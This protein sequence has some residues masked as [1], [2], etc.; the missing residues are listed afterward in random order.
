[1]AYEDSSEPVRRLR[2]GDVIGNAFLAMFGNF[3]PFFFIMLLFGS[4]P[5]I[6]LMAIGAAGTF[7]VDPTLLMMAGPK[8]F[9]IV[10]FTVIVYLLCYCIQQAAIIFGCL[11]YLDGRKA[12]FRECVGRGLILAMPLL[13][14]GILLSAGM[15]LSVGLPVLPML[16]DLS[17]GWFGVPMAIVALFAF[18]VHFFVAIP[19]AVTERP[20][21]LN[22]FRRSLA[23][24][25]GARWRILTIL[26][27][28]I[29]AA[30]IVSTAYS[31]ISTAF[32]EMLGQSLTGLVV[33]QLVGM[34]VDGLNGVYFCC[35][36]AVTYHDLRVIR[37]GPAS[38]QIS[39]VFD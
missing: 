11:R 10:G 37:E 24:T 38:T 30:V 32:L 20:G 21:I 25:R 13:L 36:A 22:S 35:L 19:A 31:F 1:M 39:A 14:I 8:G 4:I 26:L 5:V 33:L 2:I 9:L 6:L 29:V 34:I 28:A 7:V 17:W 27:I 12:E 23:L 16:A 18:L 3:L 15:L